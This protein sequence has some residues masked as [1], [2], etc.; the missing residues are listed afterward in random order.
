M[1]DE[2]HPSTLVSA[3]PPSQPQLLLLDRCPIFTQGITLLLEANGCRVVGTL[4]R[5]N[6]LDPWR[7]KLSGDDAIILLI[8][9]L[10][11][12]ID[13]FAACRWA[14]EQAADVRVIF[15]SRHADDP[16]IRI[17]AAGEGVRALLGIETDLG[18]LLDTIRMVWRG[19]SLMPNST[20]TAMVD[21]LTECELDVLRLLAQDKSFKEIAATLNI[22][23]NTVRNQAQRINE[24]LHVHSRQDAVHRARHR[25]LI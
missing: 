2:H 8:G 21:K 13:A 12:T 19:H 24:K 22:S 1:D 18:E 17:D 16:N 5:V 9:P 23:V 11:H 6:D 3:N 20:P 25:G 7:D 14:R 15:I 10:L 4:H